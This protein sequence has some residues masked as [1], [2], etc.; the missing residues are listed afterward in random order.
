MTAEF[1][2]V[3]QEDVRDSVP[4]WE[5]FLPP[6]A[7]QGAPNV[8][9]IVWDDMGFCSWD[10]YGGLIRMPTMNRIAEHGVRFSQFHTTALCSPSR[11]RS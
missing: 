8:L 5:P 10:L 11:T 4:N 9:F 3:V 1:A 7:P 6:D 2:G